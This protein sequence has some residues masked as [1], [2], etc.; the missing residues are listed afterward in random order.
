M[1]HKR[2]VVSSML[3][4]LLGIACILVGSG[5]VHAAGN[6]KTNML[7]MGGGF[8]AGKRT[9]YILLEIEPSSRKTNIVY[10][11][12]D[13]QATGLI[14]EVVL[15][16]PAHLRPSWIYLTAPESKKS[17]VNGAQTL[18]NKL[19]TRNLK[20]SRSRSLGYTDAYGTALCELSEDSALLARADNTLEV[21]FENKGQGM[22]VTLPAQWL[23]VSIHGVIRKMIPIPGVPQ[24]IAAI[25]NNGVVV[26]TFDP[27]DPTKIVNSRVLE[28]TGL[29]SNLHP[30]THKIID[31][32]ANGSSLR[33][34]VYRQ[35]SGQSMHTFMF[36]D[37]DILSMR[38][39]AYG[40]LAT[41]DTP[42]IYGL[43]PTNSELLMRSGD[44]LL[45]YSLASGWLNAQTESSNF[46]DPTPALQSLGAA[47]VPTV[48]P[49]PG[50]TLD[51]YFEYLSTQ[52]TAQ[53]TPARN[54]ATANTV[55]A[56]PRASSPAPGTAASVAAAAPVVADPVEDAREAEVRAAAERVK[57]LESLDPAQ[58]PEKFAAYLKLL[59][60]EYNAQRNV[61]KV[62]LDGE[63]TA[64]QLPYILK[65]F[66]DYQV[67]QFF[68]AP[69]I[70]DKDLLSSGLR[71]SGWNLEAINENK[72]VV[73]STI[74]DAVVS[75]IKRV[76]TANSCEKPYL[77]GDTKRP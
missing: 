30:S 40:V 8:T 7:Y 67:G 71:L 17:F 63:T 32:V 48:N 50:S 2:N 49:Q 62:I 58:H 42:R 34:M 31:A 59:I 45:R 54:A 28:V 36:Y 20:S 64:G 5:I 14:S 10:D 9:R 23:D 33:V 3:C 19:V 51:Q 52:N 38:S 65:V 4:L 21:I 47:G 39:L 60:D 44:D 72:K 13:A 56:L 73:W 69:Y 57:L 12:L 11:S 6:P 68:R 22:P 24:R 41:P 66:P 25:S 74:M 46:F 29:D 35:L 15:D 53:P 18:S 16:S 76:N 75:G 61:K 26:F 55:I 27:A 77:F 43:D 70:T 37:L 1:L